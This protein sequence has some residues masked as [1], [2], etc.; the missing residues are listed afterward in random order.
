MKLHFD[1]SSQLEITIYKY[2]LRPF[3]KSQCSGHSQCLFTSCLAC[4]PWLNDAQ[5]GP[6]VLIGL[7]PR[8][9]GFWYGFVGVCSLTYCNGNFRFTRVSE[10][11]IVIL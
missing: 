2:F 8:V 11:L 6:H 7:L 3:K 1:K 4:L 10:L 9:R 5:L